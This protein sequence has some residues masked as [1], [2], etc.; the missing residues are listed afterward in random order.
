MMLMHFANI[1]DGRQQQNDFSQNEVHEGHKFDNS[2]ENTS[3]ADLKENILEQTSAKI[4]LENE[5]SDNNDTTT[6][7]KI[8]NYRQDPPRGRPCLIW[9]EEIGLEGIYIVRRLTQGIADKSAS[10]VV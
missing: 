1:H 4:E 9:V 3:I 2:A 10:R 6:T 5:K 8:E 7:D